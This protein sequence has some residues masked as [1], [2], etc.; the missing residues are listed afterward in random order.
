MWQKPN[1]KLSSPSGASQQGFRYW[2]SWILILCSPRFGS[3]IYLLT[4]FIP[5][6][7]VKNMSLKIFCLGYIFLLHFSMVLM[8]RRGTE[9]GEL[10]QY[11]KTSSPP[12]Q[13]LYSSLQRLLPGD[14]QK[15]TCSSC[16][17]SYGPTELSEWWTSMKI[18]SEHA[19]TDLGWLLWSLSTCASGLLKKWILKK[20]GG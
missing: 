13:T 4:A 1:S 18:T 19:C 6:P 3:L 8:W 10:P 11:H 15:P 2:G 5:C 20:S 12:G 7:L 17:Y 14:K 9:N 16:T